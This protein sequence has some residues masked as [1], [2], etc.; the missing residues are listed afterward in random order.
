MNDLSARA[1]LECFH[2]YLDSDAR[3][4]EEIAPNVYEFCGAQVRVGSSAIDVA[5]G[6]YRR[7][8]TDYEIVAGRLLSIDGDITGSPTVDRCIDEARERLAGSDRRVSW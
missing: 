8:G 3:S 4:L 1:L 2:R 5:C 6:T 7:A